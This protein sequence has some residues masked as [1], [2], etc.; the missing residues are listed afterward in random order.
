[1]VTIDYPS[2]DDDVSFSYAA[3]GQRAGMTDGLGT[4][5]WAYDNL[6]RAT[7]ITDPFGKTVSYRYD[8]QSNRVQL[9]YPDDKV[10][11]Y[12]Y[13]GLNRLESLTD[14]NER[15][16]GYTYTAAGRLTQVSLPSGVTSEYSYDAVGRLN[17]ILH[18][19]GETVLANYAYT[20]DF[21]GNRVTA[22]ESVR[23]VAQSTVPAGWTSPTQFSAEEQ[24]LQSIS[25]G[26]PGVSGATGYTL[27]R[28][29]D[30]VNWVEID[31][32]SANIQYY[33]DEGLARHTN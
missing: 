1:M 32:V 2:P 33:V 13:D 24:G 17:D 12:A 29:T 9:T 4:T 5:T 25:L 27:E 3:N 16:T 14:W 15:E 11:E 30:G 28:S 26:W 7:A 10:V 31:Q 23:Q 6:G 18:Q 8:G 19:R 20:Y 21:S 22:A